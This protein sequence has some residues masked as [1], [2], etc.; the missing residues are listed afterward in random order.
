MSTVK[1]GY[2]LSSEEHGPEQLVKQ[3]ELAESSG[4]E[5]AL[6][7][8]HFHPWTDKQGSSPFVWTV[9]GAIAQRTRRLR[10]GTGVTCPIMR[11]HPALIAQAA[12]TTACLLPERFFLGVGSGENLNEHIMG[13]AWPPPEIRL[14]MLEEAVGTIRTLLDGGE[15]SVQGKFFKLVDARL[16]TLPEQPVPIYLS[17]AGEVSGKMAGRLGDGLI[18]TEPSAETIKSFNGAGGAGKP[19]LGQMTVCWARTEQEAVRTAYEIWPNGA[20][21]GRFKMELP[22]PAHFEEAARTVRPED[23]AKE[24]ICGPDAQKHLQAIDKFVKAGFDHVYVH[25]V[26]H[27]QDGFFRFYEREVLPNLDAIAA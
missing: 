5:F 18:C 16:Y 3:A 22:R 19:R 8:D 12:A 21:S 14:D 9:L 27:D 6:I 23:V 10:I 26:G 15:K 25:Q 20:L 17:A 13:Q 24:I 2:S 11:M 4:F 1:I 7:S